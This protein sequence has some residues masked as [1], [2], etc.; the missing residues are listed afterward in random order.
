MT[1]EKRPAGVSGGVHVIE[2]IE[3]GKMSEAQ[4]E[5]LGALLRHEISKM[6]LTFKE[7]GALSQ[8]PDE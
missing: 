7:A 5:A 1:E 4:R 3:A 6:L 2:F 8:A